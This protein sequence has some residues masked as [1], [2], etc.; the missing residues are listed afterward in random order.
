MSSRNIRLSPEDRA[1][2]PVLNRALTEAQN[3]R[4][5]PAMKDAI[6]RVIGAEPRATLRGLDIVDTATFA[7]AAGDITAPVGIMISAEF[8]PPDNRVLLIDQREVYP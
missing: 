2:A 4:S 3:E 7:E 8:G 1:A 5:I 6:R